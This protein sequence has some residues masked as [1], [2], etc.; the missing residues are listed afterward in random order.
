M[1]TVTQRAAAAI[2]KGDAR[3]DWL[4]CPEQHATSLPSEAGALKRLLEQA[5]FQQIM[6]RFRAADAA[7]VA[8]QTR[9]K[10]IGR[11]GLYAGTLATLLGALFLLP[12]E[13]WLDGR[14][15][16]IVSV[17]QTA[18][19]IIAFIASRTL[20]VSKPFDNWMK[21]RAVAEIA[22]IELFDRVA[23]AEETPQDGE[24]AL[25]PLKLEYFRRYQLDVQRRYYRGRGTQ[26]RQG[27]RRNNTWLTASLALTV[28]SVL[29]GLLVGMHTAAYWLPALQAWSPVWLVDMANA[30]TKRVLLAL[31]VLASAFY[32]LGVAR[33]LMDLDERN[34]SRFLTNAENLDYISETQLVQARQA[35]ADGRQDDV[36]AFVARVQDI[37]SS[38]HKEW[39]LLSERARQAPKARY[40]SEMR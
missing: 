39:L 38:E 22:R 36:L 18:C 31:G 21:Q 35:A 6:S 23:G 16:S 15:S 33:S 20:A 24:L 28:V 8:A 3:V 27:V 2:G 30:A 11:T 32:G 37:V 40:A 9:Y 14:P 7:A 10:R 17:L 13:P 1:Q 29:L 12:V 19:L 25:L 4:L 34:A 5:E 26:H